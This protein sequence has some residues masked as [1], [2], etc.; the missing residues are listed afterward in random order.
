MLKCKKV[1]QKNVEIKKKKDIGMYV[2]LR[3]KKILQINAWNAKK[4]VEFKKLKIKTV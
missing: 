3:I 1:M 4:K 2:L